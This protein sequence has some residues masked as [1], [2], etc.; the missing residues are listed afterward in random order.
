MTSNDQTL[1]VRMAKKACEDFYPLELS[2]NEGIGSLFK[3]ELTVIATAKHT[4][5]ELEGLLDSG[6]SITVS[7][8]LKDATNKTFR[9]R[10]LHGIVT[11]A[12]SAGIISGG[13][14]AGAG[15]NCYFYKLTI[16]PP[17]AR[18]RYS[19]HSRPYYRL[20]PPELIKSIL[21][22]YGIEADF[23]NIKTQYSRKLLFEQHDASDLDFI[24]T[25]LSFYGLSFAHV[26]PMA[27]D[28]DLALNKLYFSDGRTIVLPEFAYSD[29]AKKDN[30]V[31]FD[32]MKADESKNIWKM[33][34]FTMKSAIGVDG[35]NL[36]SAYP[37]ANYGSKEWH[38][39]KIEAGERFW[40]YS[41]L[42]HNYD[43]V[44]PP[45][46]ID[47]DIALML[48][49]RLTALELQKQKWQ[50]KAPNLA[51][52]PGTILELSHGYGMN[53]GDLI[54][55]LVTKSS[56]HCRAVWPQNMIVG[57]K[58]SDGMLELSFSCMDWSNSAKCKRFCFIEKIEKI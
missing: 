18:L 16:E 22:T 31:R 47:A 2:L 28:Q 23:S 32:L 9:S 58:D 34:A 11:E 17:L 6:I 44:T 37:D 25:I 41:R 36:I 21:D 26:H 27:G 10:C 48:E 52:M 42:F 15:G 45:A 8:R 55:A 1:S 38:K 33:D 19:Q 4:Q 24:N 7:Q 20:T 30:P 40:D 5:S 50:G 43:R 29:G 57:P 56:L 53:D 35:V 13:G 3:A 14:S 51:L 12:E 39:G 46:E 49:A 54:T